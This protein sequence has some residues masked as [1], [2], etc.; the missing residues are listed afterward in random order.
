[1]T[2]NKYFEQKLSFNQF[3]DDFNNVRIKQGLT[4]VVNSGIE[5]YFKNSLYLIT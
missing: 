1:M 2:R 5:K 3:I 4:R